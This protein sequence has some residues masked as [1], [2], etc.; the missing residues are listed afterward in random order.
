[1][2]KLVLL[3]FFPPAVVLGWSLSSAG[4]A[5]RAAELRVAICHKT[6]SAT[7]PY[8]RIVVTTNSARRAH[9]AHPDDIV[10]APRQCPQTL[11]TSRSGGTPIALTLRGVAEQPAPGDADGTG[12]ATL[13]LREGQGRECFALDVQ[14]I[15]LPAAGAHIHHGT[16]TEAKPLD[17]GLLATCDMVEVDDDGNITVRGSATVALRRSL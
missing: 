17:A 12:Q 13:R 6:S 2:R 3:V 5:D 16:V 7:R 14:G 4:A 11:L 8:R 1:M 10:P 9:V 15:A